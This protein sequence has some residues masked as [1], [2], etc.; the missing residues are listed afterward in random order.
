MSQ[1]DISRNNLRLD[2]YILG[3]NLCLE[4]SVPILISRTSRTPF[5]RLGEE[6]FVAHRPSL[7]IPS[8]SKSIPRSSPSSVAPATASRRRRLRPCFEGLILDLVADELAP[9][10]TATYDCDG[11]P[12][13]DWS[14]TVSFVRPRTGALSL[15]LTRASHQGEL[16]G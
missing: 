7:L 2:T 6:Q 10:G 16:M 12:A 11:A 15:S 13:L 3:A 14:P 5:D 8:R 9:L 4:R 1:M